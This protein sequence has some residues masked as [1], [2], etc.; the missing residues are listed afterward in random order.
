MVCRAA[1]ADRGGL[2]LATVRVREQTLRQT[3]QVLER[4]VAERTAELRQQKAHIESIN[5]DLVVARDAAEAS[6]RAKA[7][8]LANMSHEIRTPMNA[9]IGLTNLLQATPTTTEQREYLTAIESSSQNLLVIINDILDSS[10]MEAGKLSLERVPFRLPEAVR[11]LGAMFRFAT[12]TKGLTLTI[13]VAPNVPAAVLGDPVRLNQVLVN[14][15]G[16]AIKFTRQGGVTVSVQAVPVPEAD[17]QTEHPSLPT[18]ELARIRFAV[19]DTGIGI[20]ADKL[21]AIFE[22]FS[23]ANTSTTRE[24]G[25]TGLGLSIARNLVQLHGVSWP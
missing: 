20:A 21:G 15:V 1:A 14:L 24:F 2:V 5:A 22:D 11:R 12:E 8:F 6:R 18:A 9:V 10:K 7:Q 19:R 13:D 25:G 3:Q 16:N 4:T 17:A 23:Q